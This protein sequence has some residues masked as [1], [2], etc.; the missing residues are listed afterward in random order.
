MSW[1]FRL[2]RDISL[3][4]PSLPETCSRIA[5]N[6]APGWS[7]AAKR[8]RPSGGPFGFEPWVKFAV[9]RARCGGHRFNAGKKIS[10]TAVAMAACR[11][12]D[13]DLDLSCAQLAGGFAI[14]LCGSISRRMLDRLTEITL[15]T[16]WVGMR[17]TEP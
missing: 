2:I 4:S 9:Q 10:M 8:Q 13:V 11:A 17:V 1:A 3:F 15:Q 16:Q 14:P 6:P 7:F 5:R 12:S